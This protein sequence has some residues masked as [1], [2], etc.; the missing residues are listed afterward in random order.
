MSDTIIVYNSSKQAVPLSLRP[1]GAEFFTSEQQVT[2]NPGKQITLIKEHVNLDQV[3]NLQR[4]G[5]LKVLKN[6]Q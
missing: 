3:S 5:I 2:L 1:P 4:R 6:P